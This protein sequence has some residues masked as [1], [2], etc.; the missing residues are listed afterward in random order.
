MKKHL[1]IVYM[2]TPAFAVASLKAI[3][4]AGYHVPAVVTSPDKPAGRGR[5]IQPSDI[6]IFAQNSG[7]RVLQPVNLK[8]PSFIEELKS[9]NPDLQLVVAFRMLPE[10]VWRLPRYGTINLHASLLPQ[11]RGASPINHVIM[12]GEKVTGVTTFFID[13]DIDTGRIIL[14]REVGIPED[15]TAGELHDI[16]MNEGA[17]LVVETLDLLKNEP[18][19]TKLQKDLV[20]PGEVLKTAPKIFK[21]DCRIK[22]DRDPVTICNFIR[23]LS[24]SPAAFAE[25]SGP[26]GNVTVRIFSAVYK[27]Y[28][29]NYTPGKIIVENRK[30]IAVAVQNGFVYPLILQQA[31]K[32]KMDRVDFINGMPALESFHFS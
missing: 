1:K 28:H 27:I 17:R 5:K 24:P 29:H 31:G 9:I 12:N 16:L 3:L 4:E 23:G 15:L 6:K 11:Y 14:Q 7:L 19:K 26:T 22:W 32:N 30:E 2:G 25:L 10:I 13:E 18:V 8:D 21:E 20:K